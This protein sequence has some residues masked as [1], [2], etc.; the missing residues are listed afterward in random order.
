MDKDIV[1]IGGG[2]GGYVAAIRAAQLGLNVSVIERDKLGG[3]CL[4]RGC[5]PT[6]ALYRN[7]EILNTL[8]NIEE[9]GIAV[10]G[11]T[12]DVKKVQSRKDK[13]VYQLVSGV[14]QLMKANKVQVIY[15]EAT[16]ID[17]NTISVLTREGEEKTLTASNVIIATGSKPY[18]PSI[19]GIDLEGVVTSDGLLEFNN[20]PKDLVVLGGG[21]VGLE[22]AGIFNSMGSKVK[23]IKAS[24]NIFP[25]VDSD[26]TK[27]Y[28]SFLRKQGIEVYS[29][30]EVKKI[31]KQGDK[32]LIKA[33]G[34]KGE[35]EIP[36]D[37]ILVS[38]GRYPEIE[39]LNLDKL[40]I[41]HDRKGIKVDKNYETNIKG[42]YAIGDVNGISLLAHAASYQ[43]VSAVEKIAGVV[44]ECE[45]TPIP[46]C[47]FVF[48]EIASVG[49]TEDE[50]KEKGMNYNTSKFMFGAN[51]KALALG[52][53]E[54]FIKVISKAEDNTIIGVH[55]MG[56]H[57]S[58]LIHEGALAIAN[59]LNVKHIKH[60]VHAHPTLGEAFY[61]AVLGLENEA[62][63]LVP[64]KR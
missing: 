4:N 56:P 26:I 33:Q 58:D 12:I 62:I 43:G 2:P 19:P 3:T 16:L 9:Y 59:K 48:P 14:E 30:T 11:F 51:G 23:V 35:M 40:G 29:S 8:N 27:R 18:I 13:V 39:G 55:I 53:G 47:I 49:I 44:E 63:H 38:K 50:A 20:I 1:I 24:S 37:C 46:S 21:V 36:A 17:K 34:K 52:E 54:G 64:K 42:V 60:T 5:I 61:E 32:L 25:E 7:A 22:F 57:A 41:S 31:V 28:S 6:K 45:E 15:G 10:N